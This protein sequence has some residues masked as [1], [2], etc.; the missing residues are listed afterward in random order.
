MEKVMGCR[1]RHDRPDARR[2]KKK[3]TAPWA[4]AKIMNAISRLYA[5]WDCSNH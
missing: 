1:L 3:Q 2:V 4:K 5:G